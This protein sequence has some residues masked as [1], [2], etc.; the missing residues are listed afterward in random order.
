MER[1]NYLKKILN[2]VKVIAMVGASVDPE[3]ESH[4][5]MRFLQSRGFRVIP[6]NPLYK[7]MTI[8]DEIVYAALDDIPTP[9]DMVDVFRKPDAIQ[10][11]L[12]G[13]LRIKA[14]VFWTQL[15]VKSDSFTKKTEVP[16]L[17]VVVDECPKLVLQ[18]F[19]G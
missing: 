11:C 2:D 10:T 15:G 12:D 18:N 5:V 6:I 16:G 4:I 17:I 7:D 19:P 3:R 14:K 13:A 8:N 1:I 9:V